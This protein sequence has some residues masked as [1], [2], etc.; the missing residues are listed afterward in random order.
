M[1]IAGIAVAAWCATCA[2][3]FAVPRS[4]ARVVAL[5]LA[6]GDD[7]DMDA[8]KANPSGTS[9]ADGLDGPIDLSEEEED[10]DL[11]KYMAENPLGDFGSQMGGFDPYGGGEEGGPTEGGGA[12]YVW[13]QTKDTLSVAVPVPEGTTAK[14]VVVDYPTRSSVVVSLK[15]E[16]APRVGGELAGDVVIDESFWSLEEARDDGT[17]A[18]VLDVQKAA[19][20]RDLWHGFLDAEG[21]AAAAAVTCYCYFDVEVDG[22]AAGRV[23]IG[24]FGDDTP[25]T[26]DNFLALCRGVDVDGATY[27]YAGE[28]NVF[29]RVIP[30]FMCQ[31]GDF[32]NHN[33]TGGASVY[34]T[35]PRNG[36]PVNGNHLEIC[37]S[38]PQKNGK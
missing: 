13:Q 9:E 19:G 15:G 1:G 29:H 25:K 2:A 38:S 12:G 17:R 14:R 28:H 21:D 24:V 20:S 6:P 23:E 35:S 32:T 36:N 3:S 34:S 4:R 8:Y 31:G 27:S 18:L 37:L 26:A 33:G 11:E 7:F 5:R 22:A 16:A 10:F 30:G